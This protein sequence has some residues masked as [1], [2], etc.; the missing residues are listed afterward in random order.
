MR[1]T[2]SHL[3]PLVCAALCGLL[4]TP[5]RPADA[6]PRF[7]GDAAPVVLLAQPA[8]PPQAPAPQPVL[9]APPVAP[10]PKVAQPRPVKVN[11]SG[12]EYNRDIRPILAE[13]C[14]ACHGADSAARKASL[15]I[16]RHDDAV[17]AAAIVPGKPTESE[18]IKRIL[19]EDDDKELMPPRKT[20]KKLKPEQKELLKKW[21][22]AGAEY[23]PHWSFIPP[24]R[25]AVPAVKDK[26]WVQ[27]PIDNF[28]LA[29]LEAAGLKPA[30]EADR[31]TLARRL[32]LDLTGLPPSPAA[33]EKFVN[34][35]A[36]DAYEQYVDRLLASTACGEHR[37]RYWL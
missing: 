10:M 35:P 7:D 11:A 37:A 18:M 20:N 4:L 21:V 33:V 29:K 16:D 8:A 27:N 17:A 36:P 3:P 26:S 2:L 9:A 5:F 31:R 12:I 22:A 19:M 25:P 24:T 15:R 6:A 13:N 30:P 23:Q 14:F 28:V 32:S 1:R 34:D